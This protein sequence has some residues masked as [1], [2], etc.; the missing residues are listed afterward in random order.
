LEGH[1]FDF[2]KLLR[3]DQ[4]IIPQAAADEINVMDHDGD[5]EDSWDEQMIQMIESLGLSFE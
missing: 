2:K 3:V 4:G 5:G 1:A